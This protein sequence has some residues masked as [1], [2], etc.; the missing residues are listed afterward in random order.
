MENAE[1]KSL[2]GTKFWLGFNKARKLDSENRLI[3]KADA[4]HMI[5]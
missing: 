5:K 2:F 1:L 3:E 4:F